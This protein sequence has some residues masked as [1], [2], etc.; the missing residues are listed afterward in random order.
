MFTTMKWRACIGYMGSSHFLG[1]YDTAD[2]AYDVY[3]EEAEA[4]FGDYMRDG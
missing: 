1:E 2:E 3:L 4:L